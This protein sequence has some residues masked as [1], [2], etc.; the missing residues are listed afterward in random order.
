MDWFEQIAN[1]S[2]TATRIPVGTSYAIEVEMHKVPRWS[3]WRRIIVH[4]T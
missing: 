2:F 1:T 3:P 4:P